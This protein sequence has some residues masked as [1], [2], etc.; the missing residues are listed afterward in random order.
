MPAALAVAALSV[1][2]VIDG[3]ARRREPQADGHLAGIRAAAA[4]GIPFSVGDWL[5]R[6]LPT[7]PGAV[8]LLRPSVLVSRGFSNLRTGETASLLFVACSDARDLVGH[9]PPV[10]YPAHGQTL[11]SAEPRAWDYGAGP[12]GGTRYRFRVVGGTSGQ[13]FVVDNFMVLPDGGFG[14]DMDSVR[15]VARDPSLRRYGAGSLQ[16]VTEGSMDEVRRDAVLEELIGVLEP[17]FR[18]MRAR[19]A[20]VAPAAG[21]RAAE[22]RRE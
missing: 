14:P 3:G 22:A 5:A 6:D 19:E 12:V 7:A 17:L 21:A 18:S 16:I 4:G 10:C 13:Q 2:G 15:R 11:V 20:G 9:Y 1:A 8:A